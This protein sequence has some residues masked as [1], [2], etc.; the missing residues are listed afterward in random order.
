MRRKARPEASEDAAP[1]EILRPRPP[2]ARHEDPAACAVI[3]AAARERRAAALGASLRRAGGGVRQ[4]PPLSELRGALGPDA[5]ASVAAELDWVAPP[6]AVAA[7]RARRG[8]TLFD[9]RRFL[10]CPLQASARVL[11]PVG[12]DADAMAEAEAAIREH[13]PL[14]EVRATTIPFLRTVLTRLLAEPEQRGDDQQLVEAYD[15]AAAIKRLEGKL[16]DGVFGQAMRE[17]HL[18]LL[19]CWR[20]GLLQATGG[21]LTAPAPI[22]LGAAPEHRR[23][24]VIRPA[25][26]VPFAEGASIAIGGRTEL[27]ARATDESRVV[28]SLASSTSQDKLERD[29][30]GPFL[31]H[32]ALAALGDDGAS[33]PTRAI[34][35][36]P[37]KDGTPSIEERLFLPIT[38]EAALV[39]LGRLASELLRDVHAYFLPCEGV[40]YWKDHCDKGE[41]VGVR[42]SILLLRDDNW[43]RFASDHGPIPE[44]RDYPVPPEAE[45][46]AI[47]AR[48]FEPYFEAFAPQDPPPRKKRR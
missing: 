1:S 36:R 40:F 10:E 38:G 8:L 33:R 19:R 5:W 37:E 17:R 43:T 46:R 14:D 45:A 6:P 48:R 11:L 7:T 26:A 20:D 28:L 9:L 21:L 15:R 24:V 4:L 22:W 23:D 35:V 12:D 41:T 31:T 3:P 30:L 34:V 13:E 42:Q 16:P 29:L 27:H 18:G 2:L 32:L 47:V 44:P 39:Y 25:L